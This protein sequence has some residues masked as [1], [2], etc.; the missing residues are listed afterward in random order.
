MNGQ[1]DKKCLFK[2]S[3]QCQIYFF[4]SGRTRDRCNKSLFGGEQEQVMYK[5]GQ[6][7]LGWVRLGQVRLGQVRLGQVRLGQVRLGQ[8]RLGQVRLGQV[9]LGQPYT[10]QELNK[11]FERII[12]RRQPSQDA[13]TTLSITT[14]FIKTPSI[15]TLSIAVLRRATPS[16]RP[17]QHNDNKI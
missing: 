6:V 2:K 4:Y 12:I 11:L 8:V 15:R 5:L 13:T 10:K 1:D 16:I 9:R 3:C 17:T 7:R 14:F